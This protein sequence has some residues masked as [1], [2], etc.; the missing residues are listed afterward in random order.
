MDTIGEQI[1][2]AIRF[3]PLDDDVL[4]KRLDA[5]S[6][7]AI[8]QAARKLEAA[9]RLRRFAGPDGKIVNGLPLEVGSET[10][11]RQDPL[12]ASTSPVKIRSLV[13]PE[14]H[15]KR[16]VKDYLEA[17]G[18]MVAVA[19]GHGRGVDIDARHA[20]GRRYM[21]EAKAGLASDQQQGTYFLGALGELLQRMAEA[22]VTYGLALPVN[23]R[24][25]GLVNRL[26]QLAWERLGLVVFWVVADDGGALR[27]TVQ[28]RP[29]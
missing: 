20:D 11:V 3:R 6:R 26:P 14:D 24:Y 19:W 9:G 22:D 17:E 4:A 28:S 15:V 13:V 5:S 16:A 25:R 2:E 21:I 29:D 27:V 1:L 23:R 12:A 8:N 18:F 7:Q 10:P